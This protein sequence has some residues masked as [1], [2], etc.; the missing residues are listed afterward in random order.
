LPSFHL[1]F[2]PELRC[3]SYVRLR[4]DFGAKIDE[5]MRKHA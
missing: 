5:A 1:S 2:E 3:D 4:I